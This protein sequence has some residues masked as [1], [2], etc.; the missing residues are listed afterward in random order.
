MIKNKDGSYNKFSLGIL[1]AIISIGI[2]MLLSVITPNI[3]ETNLDSLTLLPYG[4]MIICLIIISYLGYK[5]LLKRKLS[6]P[7]TIKQETKLL[8]QNEI[9]PTPIRSEIQLQ[10]KMND[11]LKIKKQIVPEKQPIGGFEFT[12]ILPGIVTFVIG[13]VILIIGSSI[14]TSMQSALPNIP[15][16]KLS[17]DLV[18]IQET[19]LSAFNIMGIGIIVLSIMIIIGLLMGFT[20]ND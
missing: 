17:G 5:I 9:I 6:T 10:Q 19:T 4:G 18:S 3:S 1:G 14:M 7:S 20:R 2:I 13:V 15:D 8:P 11:K 12:N 16:S